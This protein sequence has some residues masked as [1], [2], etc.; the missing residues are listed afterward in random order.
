ML[1][2]SQQEK[3]NM[4]T[5]YVQKITAL[6]SVESSLKDKVEEVYILNE[7]K[8]ELHDINRKLNLDKK[9]IEVSSMKVRYEPETYCLY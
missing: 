4:E 2:A 1:K 5:K 8:K 9:R 7:C 3:I 6:K